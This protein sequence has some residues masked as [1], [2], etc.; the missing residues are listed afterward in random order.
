[1]SLQPKARFAPEE[2]LEM[3][4]KAAYKSEYHDGEIFA[5]AG[6][7]ESHIS[8]VGNLMYLLVGQFKGRDCK[9]YSN[10]MKV[11]VTATGLFTYPDV[12]I[13]CGEAR[14]DDQHK[15]ILLNPRVIIE[16]LSKST[17][18]NDRGFK[19][20]QFRKLESFRGYVLVSQREPRVETFHRQADG[21]WMFSECV[22]MEAVCRLESLDC[23]ILLSDVYDKV[24][25][26]EAPAAAPG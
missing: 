15:D 2:Y 25:L 7:S 16:V 24:T 20:A 11:R 13:L 18:A 9:A 12:A 6:A 4:R 21:K 5:M 8:I 1:M 10:D 14:F 19:F 3:E 26:G 23:Q 22:G 17:E